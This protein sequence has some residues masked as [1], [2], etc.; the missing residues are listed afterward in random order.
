MN[1]TRAYR[2]YKM[3]VKK[4]NCSRYYN[5]GGF[6]GYDKPQTDKRLIGMVATT[7][8]PCSCHM[9]A[10]RAHKNSESFSDIRRKQRCAH[11]E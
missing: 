11:Y 7:P 10:N 9:C 2:R 3:F 1:R 6:P 5:A 4:K 8:K